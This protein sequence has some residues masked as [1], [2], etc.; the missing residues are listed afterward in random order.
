MKGIILTRLAVLLTGW[1]SV[2][3]L[4]MFPQYTQSLIAVPLQLKGWIRFDRATQER[5]QSTEGYHKDDDVLLENLHLT[6]ICKGIKILILLA[7]YGMLLV[8]SSVAMGEV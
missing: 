7:E 5:Q 8:Y 1:G 6:G 4:N 2:H 3:F